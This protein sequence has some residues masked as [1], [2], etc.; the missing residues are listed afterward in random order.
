MLSVRSPFVSDVPKLVLPSSLRRLRLTVL[1][2]DPSANVIGAVHHP[3]SCFFSPREK[4]HR[5]PT[6]ESDVRQIEEDATVLLD[7]QQ[8]LQPLRMLS[9]YFSA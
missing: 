3:N 1:R 5:C 2:D 4:L 9:I 6:H 7:V 8:L